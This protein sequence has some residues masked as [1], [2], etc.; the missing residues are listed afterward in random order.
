MSSAPLR[1]VG[2]MVIEIGG[3]L[4]ALALLPGLPWE[5][6]KASIAA[7][8]SV[9]A[10]ELPPSLPPS[11]YGFQLDGQSNA[12]PDRAY[13]QRTVPAPAT[14]PRTFV[15]P[16]A[17]LHDRTAV[18][19]EGGRGANMLP[20]LPAEPQRREYVADTLDRASQQILD[21]LAQ[22]WSGRSDDSAGVS[23]RA[24]L[25]RNEGFRAPPTRTSV[26]EQQYLRPE[27]P[28][29]VPHRSI[30]TPTTRFGSP[31][32]AQ[33]LERSQTFAPPTIPL[34][35]A[36]PKFQS[37]IAPQSYTTPSTA[38]TTV[39]PPQSYYAQPR[40]SQYEGASAGYERAPL[41]NQYYAPRTN[42]PPQY[43]SAPQNP[44]AGYNAAPPTTL[45]GPT[46]ARPVGPRHVQY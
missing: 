43:N 16:P 11:G 30:P 2:A 8:Q 31:S 5:Q 24:P 41:S 25:P 29:Q 18:I 3:V 4:L 36:A 26:T 23:E 33:P 35:P 19:T 13:S 44:A 46:H 34:E 40:P 32:P 6:W 14:Q 1:M 22:P 45:T 7:S 21:S 17:S 37:D 10:A 9:E 38:A 39:A 27:Y 20:E 42:S 12:I 15:A 28:S